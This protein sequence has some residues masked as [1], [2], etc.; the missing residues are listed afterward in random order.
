MIRAFVAIPLPEA[1][2][3]QLGLLAQM[4]PLPRRVVPEALHLTLVFLGDIAEPQA[5]EVHAAFDA[6]RATRFSLTLRGTAA[7]GG[8]RPRA[9]HAALAPEPALDRLQS[10]VAQAARQAGLEIERR[11]F[12]PHVTLGRLKPGEVEPWRLE[13]ALLQTAGF[14]AGPFEVDHF[15]LYRSHL[16]RSG[17]TYEELARYDLA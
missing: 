10:K 15:C 9:V 13:Q 14:A 6:I 8:A 11:R 3:G 4:L 7:F 12:V 16:G 1:I 17:A 5:A 2:R